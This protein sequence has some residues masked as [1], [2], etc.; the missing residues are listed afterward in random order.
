[1]SLAFG[2]L[3]LLR[4][5]AYR[6]GWLRS[7]RAGV[8]VIV[9]GNLVAGGSGKTPLVLWIVGFLSARGWRPGIVSRGYGAR[10][11]EPR[12]VDPSD[13]AQ[14]VGDEPLLLA[15]RGGCP[16]WVGADRVRAA[17]ALRAQHPHIDVLV[18]DDGL[19]HYRLA[20]DV[21]IAVVDARGFGNGFLL[22]AGPLREP[23]SRLRSVDAVIAHGT[24][25]VSGYAMRLAGERLCRLDNRSECRDA[26]EFAGRRVHAVAGIGDPG[27]FF[28]DLERLG[29]DVEP[30]AFPDHHPFCAGDLE[31]G[32]GAPVVM[33]EK[34]A[35]KC[36]LFAR[37]NH[38][39]L[40][41]S[42]VLDPA[43]GNWLVEKLGGPKAA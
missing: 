27:R 14:D 29:L 20:R 33:T 37:P 25:A 28:A 13:R 40:P 26:S 17:R 18:L 38:W 24:S 6:L 9:V 3:V 43:F 16:V 10:V 23:P 42:A 32:D 19:Q 12:G 41:V 4:R 1:M 5:H 7:A 15:A 36:Q 2:A 22:P 34:D 11:D 30:H 35:V 21:E 8:P 39:V 31:F